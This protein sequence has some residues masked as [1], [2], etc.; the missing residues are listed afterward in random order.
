MG[1]RSK[2]LPLDSTA[3]GEE[4]EEVSEEGQH[5]TV[6]LSC[7]QEV[8]HLYGLLF[9]CW[10]TLR[11]HLNIPQ[12]IQ[13]SLADTL[14]WHLNTPNTLLMTLSVRWHLNTPQYT[15]HSLTDTLSWHLNTLIN[16]ILSHW[17]S[18]RCHLNTP[19]YTQLSHWHTLRDF[20]ICLNNI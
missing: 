7:L 2:N 4:K 17:Y 10:H 13:Y 19:Q 6:C 15:Q 9:S 14:R 8:M 11:W 3:L 1:S 20:N 12:Y 18:R 16:S 5:S